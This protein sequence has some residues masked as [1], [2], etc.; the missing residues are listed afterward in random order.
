MID[1]PMGKWTEDVDISLS[2][3][4]DLNVDFH[5]LCWSSKRDI[6]DFR[7]SMIISNIFSTQVLTMACDGSL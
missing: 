4:M 1:L 7:E 6:K 3:M 5:P 2:F